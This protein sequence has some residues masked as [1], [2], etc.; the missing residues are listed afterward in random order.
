MLDHSIDDLSVPGRIKV[1]AQLKVCFKGHSWCR[2]R[3]NIMPGIF[4][5]QQIVLF[6]AGLLMEFFNTLFKA[7]GIV[8]ITGK[9]K[10]GHGDF[11][12]GLGIMDRVFTAPGCE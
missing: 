8:L 9:V 3:P 12:H 10:G 7:R 5:Y 1:M 6:G 11:C 2:V 4:K